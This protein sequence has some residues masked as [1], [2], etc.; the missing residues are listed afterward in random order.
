MKLQNRAHLLNRNVTMCIIYRKQA[1]TMLFALVFLL[2]GCS[3]NNSVIP[4]KTFTD[5][6]VVMGNDNIRFKVTFNSPLEISASEK[7]NW[8]DT[9]IAKFKAGLDRWAEVVTGIHGAQEPFTIDLQVRGKHDIEGGGALPTNLKKINNNIYIPNEAKIDLGG[10]MFAENYKE[11]VDNELYL[12]IVHEVG[13]IYGIGSLWKIEQGE[14]R[15]FPSAFPVTPENGDNIIRNWVESPPKGSK[16]N[17]GLVYRKPNGVREYQKLF[18]DAIDF[19]PLDVNG[20]H[21]FTVGVNLDTK[22]SIQ[23]SWFLPDNTEIKMLSK[24]V[25]ANGN[26]LSRIT[27][28]VLEDFGWVVDYSK[29][30]AY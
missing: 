26:K 9:D 29:A 15:F 14:G 30:D 16:G 25:M 10:Y 28:G 17:I 7:R 27:L 4:P 24:E 1:T 23:G 11:I 2:F 12:T 22:E 19:L 5:T 6:V 21:L 18:G 3:K 8:T 13:H 20:G